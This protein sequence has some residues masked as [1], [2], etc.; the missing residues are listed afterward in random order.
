[1]LQTLTITHRNMQMADETG[2]T[3]GRRG[4]RRQPAPKPHSVVDKPVADADALGATVQSPT[5]ETGLTV[6]E[7]V[8]KE[9]DPK[10]DG[11][12]PTPLQKGTR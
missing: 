6:E 4:T 10:K 2:R 12:L 5:T 3:R 1:M 9:W 7:Q 8:R 11:G